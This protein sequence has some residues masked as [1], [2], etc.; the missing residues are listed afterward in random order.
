MEDVPQVK[1]L[2]LEAFCEP[3]SHAQPDAL[4]GERN[5]LWKVVW[6]ADV[7][8]GDA[9]GSN[10]VAP[11]MGRPKSRVQG[12]Q[13]RVQRSMPAGNFVRGLRQ[14]RFYRVCAR[15]VADEGSLALISVNAGRAHGRDS[16]GAS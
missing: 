8:I 7:E 2:E 13:E 11:Q 4:V 3:S 16:L 1:R 9:W 14:N 12:A 10:A 6:R 5:T 15:L